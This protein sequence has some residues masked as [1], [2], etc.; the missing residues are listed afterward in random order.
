M[1]T[2]DNGVFDDLTEST[3]RWW[4]DKD[5][6]LKP[7]F[8]AL[9]RE[10]K[11]GRPGKLSEYEEGRC[12]QA[13]SALQSKG[14]TMTGPVTLS[15]IKAV[16]RSL[17]CQCDVSMSFAERFA[18]EKMGW[19][20]R[21][22]TTGT[23]LP[24]DWEELGL[25]MLKRIAYAAHS[26]AFENRHSALKHFHRALVI[27]FDQTG[28]QL[29]PKS[30]YSYAQPKSRDVEST[31]EDDRRQITAVMASSAAGYVLPLQL[32]FQGK[33]T[34]CEATHT[35]ETTAAKFVFAHSKNHWSSLETM[36]QYIEKVIVPYMQ[37]VIEKH[38]LHPN[39][40]AVLLLDC[41]SVHISEEFRKYMKEKHQNMRLVFIPPN[42]TSKLQVADTHLNFPFKRGIRNRFNAYTVET[43]MKQ[44]ENGEE[45][46]KIDLRLSN[47]KPLVV[48]WCYQ[49]WNA[50]NSSRDYILHA[51]ESHFKQCTFDPFIKDNQMIALHDASAHK[52]DDEE[53]KADDNDGDAYDSESED[54]EKDEL[55]IMK[56]IRCGTRRS[57]REKKQPKLSGLMIR[58]DQIQMDDDRE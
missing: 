45:I 47:L 51:W 9:V 1:P 54:E 5:W 27:N 46:D 25:K 30:H 10:K 28:V 8:A 58:T 20:W 24:S 22:T 39:S 26:I 18:K 34:R 40:Q 15:V 19:I 57:T 14:Q 49:S 7:Q 11:G 16:L 43:M 17:Q 33:T 23:K 31:G 13:L 50:L 21:R 3:V 2:E 52:L 53:Y 44:L 35:A 37:R 4:F 12:I 38:G 48:E 29:V 41:W 55:D 6:N 56:E 36:K 42:C 32:I